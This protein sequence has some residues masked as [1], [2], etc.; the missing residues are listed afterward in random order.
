MGILDIVLLL[1]FVPGVVHGISKGFVQ[2]VVSL[3]SI[4]V[5]AWLAFH[6]SGLVSSFLQDY[7]TIDPKLLNV[8]A[9][10]VIIILTTLLLY[11]LGELITRIIK[12]A[13]LGW[14]NRLLGAILAIFNT[15]LVLGLLIMVFESLNARFGIIAAEKLQDSGIYCAIQDFADKIFPYLKSLVTGKDA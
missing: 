8:I 10:I 15:A 2:Q 5:G 1:C 6:F 4:F 3:V 11:W 14:L 9:F 12:I 7:F 13:T